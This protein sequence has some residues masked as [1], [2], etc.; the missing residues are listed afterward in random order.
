MWGEDPRGVWTLIVESISTN[1]SLGGIFFKFYLILILGMF[2]DW[3]LLLYGTEY[4]AQPNDHKYS[5]METF[6][7]YGDQSFAQKISQQVSF[8]FF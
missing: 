5:P 6:V 2:N 3:T 7:R 8:V 1:P 4:P